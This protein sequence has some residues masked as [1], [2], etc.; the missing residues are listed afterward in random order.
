[1]LIVAQ[2]GRLAFEAVLFAASFARFNRAG[3][4]RLWVAE[5]QPGPLWPKDPRIADAAIRD[6]LTGFGAR[7]VP[8]ESRHFGATY[9]IGNKIEAL[10]ALPEGE[11]FV[12]F[13]TDTLILSDL[14]AVPFDFDRPTASL[15]CED[16]WPK[17][18]LYGPG[19]TEIWRALYDQEGLDFETSL[20]RGQ[21]EGYWRRY[22]YFNAG[23]FFYRCPRLFGARFLATALRI[24]DAPPAQLAGQATQPWLD[25]IALP[26]VIHGLGGGRDTLPSGLLDGTVSCHYRSLPLLYAREADSTVALLEALAA[27][28]RVKKQL[29]RY[30]PFRHMIYHGRGHKARALF[31]RAALPK[32]EKTLRNQLRKAGYWMR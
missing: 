19:Y 23:F 4:F 14:A 5:P 8:F 2:D 16:T 30:A 9:P 18:T 1:M 32:R 3:R 22:L 25:Q 11:P 26:L 15:N 27:P 28:N 13:D 10:A 12:F 7:I 31:D 29:K 24:R 6:L 21:P 17:I 20:D